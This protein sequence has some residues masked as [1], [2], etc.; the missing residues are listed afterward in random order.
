V[1]TKKLDMLDKEELDKID[2]DMGW[3]EDDED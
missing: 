2:M 3:M 1:K